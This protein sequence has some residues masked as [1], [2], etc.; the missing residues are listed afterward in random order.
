MSILDRYLGKNV[1][2]CIILVSAFLTIITAI[3]T[4]VDQTRYIGRGDIGLGFLVVHLL[5]QIPGMVVMF[6]PIAVLLGGVIALGGLA[7]SSELIILQAVGISKSGIVLCAFKT[8]FPLIVIVAVLGEVLIPRLDRYAENRYNA[9][10]HQGNISITYDGLWLKEGDSF[11]GVRYIMTDGSLRDVV[12]YE[13]HGQEVKSISRANAGEYLDDAWMMSGVEETK[14]VDG[15]VKIAS[16]DKQK[17]NLSLNPQRVQI[18][19]VS[20]YNLTVTGLNDYINYLESNNQNA[21]NYRLQLYS[22]F[23]TPFAVVVMLLLAASTVF[24]PL[25]TMTMGTRVLA[26]IGMGFAF[27]VAN[28][29]GAPFAL[30]YGLPPVIGATL[31]T[32][33]FCALALYLLNRPV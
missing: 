1:L 2:L 16:Y 31:P 25:R 26:G 11:I 24:G 15:A 10:A 5:L 32:L 7:R 19:G 12:R 27:Y 9:Y 8:V 30:V 23:V 4:F 33:L 29:I 17:W 3:I 22:K 14:F 28:Q 6:F 20:G 18:L 21:D 13:L